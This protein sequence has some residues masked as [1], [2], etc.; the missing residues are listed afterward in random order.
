MKVLET[1]YTGLIAASKQAKAEEKKE[2]GQK[3]EKA[4]LLA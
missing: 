3:M 1:K 2:E 4:G